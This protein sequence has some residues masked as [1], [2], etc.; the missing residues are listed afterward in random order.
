MYSLENLKLYVSRAYISYTILCS[1][2]LNFSRKNIMYN[3]RNNL[4][5][6]FAL[7]EEMFC[8]SD[9]KQP[10]IFSSIFKKKICKIYCEILGIYII[11]T[12][13]LQNGFD[14]IVQLH[15]GTL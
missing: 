1:C 5:S 8:Q 11:S 10:L 4:L 13:R 15:Q 2:V 12:V 6:H 7:F 14:P 9:S 3:Q